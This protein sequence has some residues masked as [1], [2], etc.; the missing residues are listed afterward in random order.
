[1]KKIIAVALAC[2]ITSS[3]TEKNTD[4]TFRTEVSEIRV[5]LEEPAINLYE[6]DKRILRILPYSNILSVGVLSK[7]RDCVY[8]EFDRDEFTPLTVRRYVK[9]DGYTWLYEYGADGEITKRVRLLE[10]KE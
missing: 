8:L 5:S 10:F 9:K 4:K 3:C 2:M 1:M 6:K 7:G